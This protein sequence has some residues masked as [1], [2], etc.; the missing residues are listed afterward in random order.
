MLTG[1]LS[2]WCDDSL[3]FDVSKPLRLNVHIGRD[4]VSENIWPNNGYQVVSSHGCLR[5]RLV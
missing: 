2:F 3:L 1:H 4:V 5:R